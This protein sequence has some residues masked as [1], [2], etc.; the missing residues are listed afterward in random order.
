MNNKEVIV[1][2]LQGYKLCNI[3]WFGV[4]YIHLV[5]NDILTDKGDPFDLCL[6]YRYSGLTKVY[7]NI[8]NV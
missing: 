1:A 4:K 2:L 8:G 7:I 3:N 6:A 5:G